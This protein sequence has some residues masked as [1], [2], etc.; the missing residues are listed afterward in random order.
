M[1]SKNTIEIDNG[2]TS[3]VSQNI[4][5][6]SESNANRINDVKYVVLKRTICAKCGTATVGILLYSVRKNTIDCLAVGEQYRGCGIATELVRRALKILDCSRPVYVNTFPMGDEKGK[7][8][9]ALYK[10]FGF[11]PSEEIG[12]EYGRTV[13]KFVRSPFG[14]KQ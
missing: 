11:R 14:G 7:A 8:A 3:D 4:Q 12:L 13:Q 9:H 10:K 6:N 5:N 1:K 2:L